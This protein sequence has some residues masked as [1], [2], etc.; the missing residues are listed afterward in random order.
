MSQT[1]LLLIAIA[2]GLITVILLVIERILRMRKETK[3]NE[4]D[5]T[6]N[7]QQAVL[8]E[9]LAMVVK[10]LS[11]KRDL[12][13]RIP[14]IAKKITERLPEASFLPVL[15]RSAKDLFD[16]SQV[17][18]FTP[19]EGSSDYTIEVGT[20]FPPDWQ[21]TIRIASDEGLLGIAIRKKIVAARIDPLSTAG[22]RASSR[23]LEQMGIPP[24]FAAPVFGSS[25]ILGVLVITGCP[26]PL[27]E[28]RKYVSMLADLFSIAIQKASLVDATKTGVWKD[29]LTGLSTRLHFLQRFETEIRRTGNYQQSFALFMF[30][31]DKF[32]QINDTYG[33]AIGDVVIRKVAEITKKHTRSSDLVGR[34]GGDEFLVLLTSSTDE[35][36]LRY[37]DNIRSVISSTEMRIQGYDAPLR[38]TISGGL[39]FYPAH[40]QSTSELMHAADHALYEAKRKGRDQVSVA[41]LRGLADSPDTINDEPTAC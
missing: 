11:R 21:G 12:A 40:G 27:E 31:I 32:K 20:G 5:R 3:E 24:D 1:E 14:P 13:E 29:E 22:L 38:L 4:R 9:Q 17:G 18:F 23:S 8:R 36:S 39:S 30:D 7:Q 37:A 33:H 6:N 35:Q 41:A 34:Y 16:A 15:V 19:V 28:E 2:L 25:G 10:E 26:Y